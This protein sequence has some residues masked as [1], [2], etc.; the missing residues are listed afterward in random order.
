MGREINGSGRWKRRNYE[1]FR[2]ERKIGLT[3]TGL[4]SGIEESKPDNVTGGLSGRGMIGT[5]EVPKKCLVGL[6]RRILHLD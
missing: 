5:G 3:P 2:L 1:G 4:S 6:P